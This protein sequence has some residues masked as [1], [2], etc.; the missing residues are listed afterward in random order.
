MEVG[1]PEV[2]VLVARRGLAGQ[3]RRRSKEGE[4]KEG[5]GGHCKEGGGGQGMEG[6]GEHNH[7]FTQGQ[8][9][10]HR[11]GFHTDVHTRFHC[12]VSRQHITA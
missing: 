1:L 7:G 8:S 9:A 11:L 3:V 4:G 12:P 10:K 2:E 5:G 6:G